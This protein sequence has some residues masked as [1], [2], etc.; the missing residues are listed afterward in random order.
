MLNASGVAVGDYQK[1]E[2]TLDAKRVLF[3]SDGIS[4]LGSITCRDIVASRGDGTGVIFFTGN[5]YLY[6]DG[7]NYVMPGANLFVNGSQVWHGGNLNPANATNLTTGTLASGVMP[8][9]LG[10]NAT[11]HSNWND[12]N[13]NGLWVAAGVPN[14]PGG[15][16]WYIGRVTVHNNDWITQE[17]WDFTANPGTNVWRRQK[18]AGVWG[19]WT[20]NQTIAGVTF[21]ENSGVYV[22]GTMRLRGL[23]DAQLAANGASW[24]RIPRTFVQSGDPGAAAADGDLWVW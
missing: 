19:A 13:S 2:I 12:A 8:A 17:V 16:G 1:F 21:E 5:R 18:S 24:V 9:G 23:D 14:S 10:W 11:Q 20:R 22:N 15:G 3:N 6:Y 4:T 7:V